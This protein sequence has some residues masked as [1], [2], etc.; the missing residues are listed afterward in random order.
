MRQ[1][2]LGGNVLLTGATGGI[3]H[4]IARAFAAR[5][6]QLVL[7]GR[8]VDELERLAAS[9]RGRP[10]ACDLAVPSELERLIAEAGEVDVLVANAAL[11]AT[12]ELTSFSSLQ[13][14][15]ILDVNLRAPIALSHALVPGMV[16]RRRGHLVF[17]SS[18]A[19]RATSP[20]SSMYSATKFGLRGFGLGLRQDLRRDGVGVSVVSA[21]FVRDAGMFADA[22]TRLPRGVGTSTSEQVAAEIIRAIERDRAEV[23]VAPLTLRIGADIASV[24]PGLSEAF[25]R[26]TRADRVAQELTTGQSNKR[27]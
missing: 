25:Q 11:P 27:P 1:G 13:L 9:V 6:A 17:V 21:G 23:T 26:L 24:A 22:N 15:T 2:L 18:L 12:G 19:G 8:R 7:T 5:G 14:D 10:I 16:Q 20:L 3:G 4:A